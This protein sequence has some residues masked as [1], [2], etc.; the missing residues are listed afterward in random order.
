MRVEPACYTRRHLSVAFAPLS[1]PLLGAVACVSM[2]KMMT[3]LNRYI[4]L[5]STA[6]LRWSDFS[7]LPGLRQ[8]LKTTLATHLCIGRPLVTTG[9]LESSFYVLDDAM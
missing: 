3:E 5:Q 8:P 7:L 1:S 4:T 2:Q 6:I 9:Q